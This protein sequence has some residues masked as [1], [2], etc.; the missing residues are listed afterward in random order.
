MA[1]GLLVLARCKTVLLKTEGVSILLHKT[2]LPSKCSAPC[3]IFTE[4][5][6]VFRGSIP[7]RSTLQ[8]FASFFTHGARLAISS[9]DDT[10]LPQSSMSSAFMFRI[11]VPRT[12]M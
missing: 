9:R 11:A 5:K 1:V 6:K 3:G 10:V 7:W 12:T 2:Y 4:R 8:V